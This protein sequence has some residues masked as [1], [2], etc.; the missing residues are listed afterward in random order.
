M[1][2][3]GNGEITTVNSPFQNVAAQ[4]LWG[5]DLLPVSTGRLSGVG[6]FRFEL[7][8]AYLGSFEQQPVTGAGFD[9]LA[10]KDGRPHW[11]G[12]T[13]LWWNKVTL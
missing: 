3:N 4:K 9:E 13:S 1:I 7:A 5:I 11:R 12:R 2:R 6:D 10:G 8:A